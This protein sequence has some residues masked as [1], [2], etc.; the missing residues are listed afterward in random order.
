MGHYENGGS[1]AVGIATT[2]MWAAVW[3][4]DTPYIEIIRRDF[5]DEYADEIREAAVRG[6]NFATENGDTGA[7]HVVST[8]GDL[9]EKGWPKNYDGPAEY[10]TEELETWAREE[11][12]DF[13]RAVAEG[14]GY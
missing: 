5:F 4:V 1:N 3:T 6:Q 11:G 12:G 2:S 14:Y 7:V 9:D 8:G 10:V 13:E